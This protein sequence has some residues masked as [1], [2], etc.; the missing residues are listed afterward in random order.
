MQEIVF[1]YMKL[2]E[3]PGF[4]E[5]AVPLAPTENHP[6]LAALEGQIVTLISDDLRAQGRIV[7]HDGWWFGVLTSAVEVDSASISP[8]S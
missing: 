3:W 2:D 5:R 8:G 6:D 1:E 4:A 7:A